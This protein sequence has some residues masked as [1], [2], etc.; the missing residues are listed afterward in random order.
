MVDQQLLDYDEFLAEIKDWM[1][2]AQDLI[3]G[4]YDQHHQELEFAEVD[5]VWLRLHPRMVAT[6]TNKARGKLAL[7][8]YG[9][10]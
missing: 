5:W 8:F 10:F 7:K 3:K 4:N 9:P 2:H 6:L 1:L